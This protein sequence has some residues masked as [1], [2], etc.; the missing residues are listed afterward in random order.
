MAG[1][2]RDEIK[3]DGGVDRLKGE[4]KQITSQGFERVPRGVLA[5]W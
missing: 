1:M 5:Y 2:E 3:I 4:E